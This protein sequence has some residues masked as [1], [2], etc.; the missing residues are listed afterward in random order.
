MDRFVTVQDIEDSEYVNYLVKSYSERES[1]F[2]ISSLNYCF[3]INDLLEI[4]NLCCGT[5][6]LDIMLAKET[7]ANID[8]IDGSES[9]IE[10][11]TQNILN[12]EFTNRI[13]AKKLNIPFLIEKKYDLIY[14]FHGLSCL[15][16]PLDFWS[17][18][19]N[20]SKKGTKIFIVDGNRPFSEEITTNLLDFFEKNESKNHQTFAKNLLLN[21]FTTEEI[22]DQLENAQLN[23][24]VE[25]FPIEQLGDLAYYNIVWGTI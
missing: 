25:K 18:I 12:S 16:E 2:F 21:L 15:Q 9:I 20:H 11:A 24:N 5:G 7:T 13:V 14:S 8:I 22:I 3:Q 17:T 19:K 6:E 10:I 1:N 4:M 23:L